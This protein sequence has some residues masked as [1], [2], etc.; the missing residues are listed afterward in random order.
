MDYETIRLDVDQGVACITLNRPDR[1][2]A[3][4]PQMFDEIARALDNLEGARVL[5]LRGEGRG[6]C[7][8]ADLVARGQASGKRGDNSYR[9]LTAHYNPV[10]LKFAQLPMPVVSAVHGPAA[11]IGCGLALTA[12][13]VIM[14][15]TA[16]LL[17]AFAKIG[18]GP[19]GGASWLLPRIVGKARAMR[20]M[21]LAER[22]HGPQA[23][24]WGLIYK[25]V[26]DVAVQDEAFALA[27]QLAEGPTLAFG[28][29]RRLI[30]GGLDLSFA[31]ALQRE[32]ENQR[33]MGNSADA[34]EG[35]QAFLE[36]RKANFTGK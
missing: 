19:D 4:T 2:N 25:C 7:S 32:A 1:L 10:M 13:F 31:E 26:D 30:S 33:I 9:T 27:R 36:K 24:E 3:V 28:G 6:F 16:Y 5:V 11:G 22:I 20:M 18:L 34:L 23:E 15:Q 29:V 8:G 14:G 12:D 21:M 35:G 17:Q